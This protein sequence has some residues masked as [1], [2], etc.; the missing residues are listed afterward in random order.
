LIEN[1]DYEISIFRTTEEIFESKIINISEN[2]NE[3]SVY[4]E[5]LKTELGL[6]FDDNF[7]FSFENANGEIIGI[8]EPDVNLDIYSEEIPIQ[9]IDNEANIKPGFLTIRVY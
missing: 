9:Y 7:G 1:T 3:S 6:A 8:P 2:I 4:Y 5:D